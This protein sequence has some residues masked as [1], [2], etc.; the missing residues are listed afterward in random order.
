M[1]Y[2]SSATHG[3]D[4]GMTAALWP[5]GQ[6]AGFATAVQLNPVPAML[7]GQDGR[8]QMAN[9]ALEKMFGHGP[10]SLAGQSLHRLLPESARKRHD[11]LMQTYWTNATQRDMGRGRELFGCR[12]DG[13]LI[14]VEIGLAPVNVGDR[15]LI[16]VTVLDITE[17][18]A[19]E[20][21]LLAALDA[22]ASAMVLLTRAGEIELLNRAACRILG[23]DPRQLIG[24]TLDSHVSPDAW[25]GFDDLREIY[26]DQPVPKPITGGHV[27]RLRQPSGQETPVQISLSPTGD[28]DRA[29]VMATL[30]DMSKSFAHEAEL[31]ARN[32]RLAALSDE[33]TQFAYSAS[34]DLRAP[35]ATI[36]GLLEL[37]LEDFDDGEFE[38]CR[39]NIEEAL[40]TSQRNIRKVET[41][42]TLARM[43][44]EGTTPEVVDLT[45]AITTCWDGLRIPRP[46]FTLEIDGPAQV[47]TERVTLMTAVEHLLTNA[48]QFQDPAKPDHWVAVRIRTHS[49][50]CSIA[51]SDNGAGI[52]ESEI[53][54]IF[55]IFRRSSASAGD[56]L[57]LAL[58]QKHVRR[59]GGSVAVTS[60]EEGTTF[61][62]TFPGMERRA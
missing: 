38:E 59:L 16:F 30:V 43:G 14:P 26:F 23:A 53:P 4:A 57:G 3:S 41:V 32:D 6:A 10:E 5:Q 36:S 24:T 62:L 54:R 55:D 28:D 37:C 22:S 12:A 31:K 34:H 1:I 49:D 2:A 25:T 60:C 52:P 21:R 29:H 48:C 8:I 20:H 39:A 50:P 17:R 58:V 47:L 18:K 45:Q 56:G 9:T 7:V 61:I 19:S 11:Q 13:K 51:V 46:A 44:A 15:E 42:L 27:I 40:Q 35:L 33:L